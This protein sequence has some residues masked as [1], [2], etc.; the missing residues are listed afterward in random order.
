MKRKHYRYGTFRLTSSRWLFSSLG[1]HIVTP[2][3]GKDPHL[4]ERTSYSSRSTYFRAIERIYLSLLESSLPFTKYDASLRLRS[5]C[6]PVPGGE[7]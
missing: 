1:S 6:L 3:Y 4:E 7:D 5:R 2:L